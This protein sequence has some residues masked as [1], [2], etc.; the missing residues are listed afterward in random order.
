MRNKI[1]DGVLLDQLDPWSR[2]VFD[3]LAELE[4]LRRGKW[5]TWEGGVLLLALDAGPTGLPLETILIN[6]EDQAMTVFVRDF[7]MSL[8][9]RG[10]SFEDGVA[11]LKTMLSRW[12]A[13]ELAVAA[14]FARGARQGAVLIETSRQTEMIP[15]A[16]EL[17][18]AAAP[19]PG[20][21]DLLVVQK[22]HR[23]NDQRLAV[24]VNGKLVGAPN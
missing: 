17:V 11:D 15:A 5:S 4:I 6:T 16:F 19:D 2:R 9:V 18:Q 7:Q 1:A 13:D 10:K 21:M 14:F 23:D 8:P 20:G 3:A 22:P 12:F 24:A